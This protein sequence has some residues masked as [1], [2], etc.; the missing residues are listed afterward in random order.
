MQPDHQYSSPTHSNSTAS[1]I[2]NG[3]TTGATNPDTNGSPFKATP[4][5]AVPEKRAS[6]D[7][8]WVNVDWNEL[9]RK[10]Q[11]EGMDKAEKT[12]KTEPISFGW[13]AKPHFE[14]PKDIP[15]PQKPVDVFKPTEHKTESPYKAFEHKAPEHKAESPYK[16]FEH[17]VESPYKAP[18]HKVESPYKAFEHKV[19]SPYKAPEHKTE[20]PYKAPEHKIE[21]PYKASE[22]KTESPFK[23]TDSFAK[24]VAESL[25][26]Q[27][28]EQKV[29]NTHSNAYN[30]AHS[31]TS[32]NTPSNTPGNTPSKP[33]PA[34]SETATPAREPAP[35]LPPTISAHATP[36]TAN[37]PDA[38]ASPSKA[39]PKARTPKQ[40]KAS[41][42]ATPRSSGRQRKTVDRLSPVASDRTEM[43]AI[44]IPSGSGTKFSDITHST[45]SHWYLFIFLVSKELGKRKSDY[46]SLVL[47]HR[48]IFGRPGEAA[49]RKGNLRQFNGLSDVS[50][51]ICDSHCRLGCCKNY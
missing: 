36:T 1:G 27:S 10:N 22:H 20:S 15:T 24:P 19:E 30:N 35:S 12:E 2:A 42:P 23:A 25:P 47:L 4:F 26:K 14:T 28:V 51:L 45:F 41:T 11:T 44:E 18:E 48:I 46:P 39:T 43:K 38:T 33:A 5:G 13:G 49:K 37:V 17:K 32:S 7:E 8:S 6:I 21:S 34:K 29:S 16:A 50:R 9:A 40:S 31:N 3:A